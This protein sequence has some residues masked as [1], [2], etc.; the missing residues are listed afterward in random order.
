MRKFTLHVFLL[1]S[2]FTLVTGQETVDTVVSQETQDLTSI[3]IT[4]ENIK[5][6]KGN[7]A[8]NIFTAKDGFPSDFKK[9][10]LNRR[11]SLDSVQNEF[12]IENIP[13]G[14]YAVAIMHDEN[15]NDKLDKNFFR[16]PKEGYAVSNNAK[17]GK[18]GPPKFEAA[19]F[20]H[21][22]TDTHLNLTMLY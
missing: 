13:P 6:Q 5:N 11:F 20:T 3:V 22:N 12:I 19:L 9:A 1:L 4:I 7:I 14:E 18:F 8:I 15:A 2:S 21:G 10:Y 17:P 16:M